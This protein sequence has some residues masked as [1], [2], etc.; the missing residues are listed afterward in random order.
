M[1]IKPENE[2]YKMFLLIM[3]IAFIIYLIT[4]VRGI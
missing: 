3:F 1:N 2:I 4:V